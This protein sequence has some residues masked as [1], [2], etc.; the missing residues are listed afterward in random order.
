MHSSGIFNSIERELKD[1]PMLAD[2]NKDVRV[3]FKDSLF[4]LFIYFSS[5]QGG[6]ARL[7]GLNNP[8]SGGIYVLIFVT[9]LKLDI[10]N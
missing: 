6:Q 4:S 3:R 1:K 7:F 2:Q 5:L 10:I 9:S 8:T